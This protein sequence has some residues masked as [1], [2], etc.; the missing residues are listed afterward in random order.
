[1][2]SGT[3]YAILTITDDIDTCTY[4]ADIVLQHWTSYGE[5]VENIL[6]FATKEAK[7]ARPG[8]SDQPRIVFYSIV[9]D[10]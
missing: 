10:L 5:V 8:F 7:A 4:R 6:K 1:M 9:E 2:Q 3:Y